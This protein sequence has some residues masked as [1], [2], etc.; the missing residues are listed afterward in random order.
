MRKDCRA[1]D[2]ADSWHQRGTRVPWTAHLCAGGTRH[3]IEP[4]RLAALLCRGM[5]W[6][7]GPPFARI[8]I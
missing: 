6:S 8:Y 7:R 2:A 5:T 1:I 4:S 3:W